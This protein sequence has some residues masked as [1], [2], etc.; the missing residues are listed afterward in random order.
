MFTVTLLRDQFILERRTLQ[1]EE[2]ALTDNIP[3]KNKYISM[4][5]CMI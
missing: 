4:G 1:Q 5:L 3:F 2:S